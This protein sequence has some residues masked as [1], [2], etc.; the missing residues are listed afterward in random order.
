MPLRPWSRFVLAGLL[1]GSSLLADAGGAAAHAGAAP[2]TEE[3]FA[4]LRGCESGGDYAAAR[5]RYFGAYQFS[6]ATWSSLGYGGLPH[7]AAPEVQDDAARRL[8]GS[9]GW[10]PWPRCARRLGLT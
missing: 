9:A 6:A 1:C 2:A 7:Q 8:Q 5:G 3:N 4:R 10:S